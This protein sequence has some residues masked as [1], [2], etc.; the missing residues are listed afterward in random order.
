MFMLLYPL[1]MH[2]CCLIFIF[3]ILFDTIFEFDTHWLHFIRYKYLQEYIVED[4]QGSY[5]PPK[6]EPE[7]ESRLKMLKLLWFTEKCKNVFLNH[8]CITLLLYFT[9]SISYAWQ[10]CLLELGNGLYHGFFKNINLGFCQI[11]YTP[12]LTVRKNEENICS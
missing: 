2:S 5:F 6:L 7:H 10:P 11:L 9:V 1:F 8:S 4:L 12:N 3:P